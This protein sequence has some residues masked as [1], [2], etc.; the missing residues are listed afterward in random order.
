MKRYTTLDTPLGT[1]G[2][3]KYDAECVALLQRFKARAVLLVVIEGELGTGMSH[4]GDEA[5]KRELPDVLGTVALNIR[6]A[7]RLGLHP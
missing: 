7:Q 1:P 5:S 6:A 2:G 3:G 4:S